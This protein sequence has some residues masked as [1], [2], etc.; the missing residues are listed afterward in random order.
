MHL[1]LAPIALCP[2]G[3][4]RIVLQK[5]GIGSPK[6]FPRFISFARKWLMATH[7]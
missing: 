2:S 1:A 7:L 4:G 6:S 3:E 5:A